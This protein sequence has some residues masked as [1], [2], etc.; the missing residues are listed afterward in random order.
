M[1]GVLGETRTPGQV[2]KDLNW[3]FG[4]I[5]SNPHRTLESTVTYSACEHLEGCT[6]CLA[7]IVGKREGITTPNKCGD[8]TV[9]TKPKASYMGGETLQVQA[10]R[11]GFY[12]QRNLWRGLGL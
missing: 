4:N 5:H 8:A 2:L 11:R 1:E 10:R 7:V 9:F 3:R 6:T 12:N